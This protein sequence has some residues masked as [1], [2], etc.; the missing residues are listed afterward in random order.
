MIRTRPN[1]LSILYIQISNS[2]LLPLFSCTASCPCFFAS[3]PPCLKPSIPNRYKFAFSAPACRTGRSRS[4]LR[5]EQSP[6][7]F[8]RSVPSRDANFKLRIPSLTTLPP[9]LPSLPPPPL[10]YSRRRTRVPPIG[11]RASA[12]A[13]PIGKRDAFPYSQL[14]VRS[15]SPA[16]RAAQAKRRSTC[17]S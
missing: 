1:S 3:M 2:Q 15:W 12:P 8:P 11:H 7:N 5:D 13:H 4:G 9:Q 6:R 10:C 16:P 14:G 17:A